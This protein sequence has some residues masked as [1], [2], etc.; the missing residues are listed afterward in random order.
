MFNDDILVSTTFQ[1]HLRQFHGTR[2][3]AIDSAMVSAEELEVQRSHLSYNQDPEDNQWAEVSLQSGSSGHVDS[4][5]HFTLVSRD[6]SLESSIQSKIQLR[7]FLFVRWS[8]IFI[9]TCGTLPLLCSANH[10]QH[11]ALCGMILALKSCLNGVFTSVWKRNCSR[12]Y[13]LLTEYWTHWIYKDTLYIW[14]FV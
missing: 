6:F 13:Q 14:K 2:Y 7:M 12:L 10:T 3:A 5:T 11:L 4:W 9:L 8:N 1:I